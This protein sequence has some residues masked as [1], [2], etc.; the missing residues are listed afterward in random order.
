VS[1]ESVETY[2]LAHLEGLLELDDEAVRWRVR[3][4]QVLLEQRMEGRCALDGN[5]LATQ[6]AVPSGVGEGGEAMQQPALL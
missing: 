5:E 3:I 4:A 1:V 2:L 6:L